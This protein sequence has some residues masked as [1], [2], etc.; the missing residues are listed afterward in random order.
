MEN[1]QL[2]RLSKRERQIMDIIYMLGEATAADVLENLGEDVGD[3]SIRKLIRIVEKK[4]YLK[5]RREGHSYVYMPVVPREEASVQALRHMLKTFFDGS[6]PKA[7]SALL[8]I[9]GGDLSEEDIDEISALI[10]EAEE[11]ER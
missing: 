10:R 4:G 5:H 11:R 9:T 6:A 3:A 2:L 7:V 1:R 8:D